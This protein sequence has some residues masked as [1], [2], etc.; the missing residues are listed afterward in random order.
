MIRV[1][2]AEDSST[3]RALLVSILS[4]EAGIHVVGEA[5]TGTEAVEMAERLE[6]DL[7]TMD[8]QM[9]GLDGIEATRRVMTRSPRPILVV[10]SAAGSDVTLSLEAM[11]AGAL[12]V[13]RKPV[14]VTSPDYEGDRRQL[15]SM[16]RAL[17][18]VKVVRRHGSTSITTAV[19]AS[20]S[21]TPSA[22]PTW[23]MPSTSLELLA[24]GASTGGPAALRTILS[25][26]PASFSLPILIVQHI[27][28][29]FT[30]GLASWLGDD[31]ALRVKLAE[32]GEPVTAGSVYIAPDDRHL[33]VRRDASGALRILLDSAPLIGAFRPSATYLFR[34]C[35]A[36]VGRGVLALILTGMGDDGVD[37]LRDV[38]RAGGQVLA[39]DEASSVIYGMPREAHR[40]GIVHH[41]VSLDRVASRLRQMAP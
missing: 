35:A 38:H 12:M 7:I 10:S 32:L 28:Q 18:Q 31:C 4:A 39:Q 22:M 21:R 25:D 19:D 41:V 15:V 37:G 11:R 9:P 34:S 29:G 14:G 13:I 5:R 30:G 24:I 2:V 20:V 26:L 6:P 23:T 17:A 16:V 33:G 8:V 3:A 1:V 36:Q 40:A 27:A